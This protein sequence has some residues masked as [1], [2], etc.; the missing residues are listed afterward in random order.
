VPHIYASAAKAQPV[1]TSL[2]TQSM[3][4]AFLTW[5]IQV[6]SFLYG[7]HLAG[8]IYF[9]SYLAARGTMGS[10]AIP[11]ALMVGKYLIYWLVISFGFKHLFG[12]WILFGLVAGIYLSLPILYWVNKRL[13]SGDEDGNRSKR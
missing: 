11:F 6:L 5:M 2:L 4:N 1:P 7:I 3:R 10:G 12:E 13:S 8:L 9:M